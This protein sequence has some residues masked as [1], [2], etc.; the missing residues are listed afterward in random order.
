MDMRQNDAVVWDCLKRTIDAIVPHVDVFT[1]A[2]NTL[3]YYAPRI[4]KRCGPAEFIDVADVVRSH[5]AHLE[6]DSAALL[7]AIPVASLD[8][9]SPYYSLR[10]EVNFERPAQL[11]SLHELI[12]EI[13]LLGGDSSEIRGRFSDIVSGLESETV[14]LAC[15]ELPLVTATVP[16]KSLVDVN[17]L[18]A[19]QL[20]DKALNW[21]GTVD[22]QSDRMES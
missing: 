21:A 8:E 13:K 7:G 3:H 20:V 10:E 11:A 14:F 1:V 22:D 15:T 16:G 6:T 4:R 19:K 9:W 18:L 17:D 12:H 5:L 2:C